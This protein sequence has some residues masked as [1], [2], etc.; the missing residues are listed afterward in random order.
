MYSSENSIETKVS[1]LALHQK[2]WNDTRPSL[3]T[4]TKSSK[5]L[6]KYGIQISE[7]LLPCN[8]LLKT[9]W[10]STLIID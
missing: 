3:W 6:Q 8:A 7:I 10:C 1:S 4:R 9:L 2:A 5:N